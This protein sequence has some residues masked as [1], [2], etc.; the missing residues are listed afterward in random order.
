[1]SDR[2][3]IRVRH[4]SRFRLADVVATTRV[5]PHLIRV[6]IGGEQLRIEAVQATA[7]RVVDV[8]K[9]PEFAKGFLLLPKH[10]RVEQSIGADGFPAASS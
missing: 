2:A 3:T 6:T 4:E 7:D 1:M 8:V 10:W 5:T 9:R